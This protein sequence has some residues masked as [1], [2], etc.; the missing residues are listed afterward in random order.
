MDTACQQLFRCRVASRWVHIGTSGSDLYPSVVIFLL[1][2]PY[3]QSL[4]QSAFR[5]VWQRGWYGAI[6]C[7]ELIRDNEL[8]QIRKVTRY[9]RFDMLF[10]AIASDTKISL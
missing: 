4:T 8:W 9:M 7:Y 1:G 3:V 6:K 2:A 5:R 10:A